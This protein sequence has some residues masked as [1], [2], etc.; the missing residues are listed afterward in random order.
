MIHITRETTSE[1]LKI[2]VDLGIYL[3]ISGMS[4]FENPSDSI[5]RFKS[6]IPLEKIVFLSDSPYCGLVKR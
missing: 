6:E 3:G 1:E 5:K 4:F 2:A